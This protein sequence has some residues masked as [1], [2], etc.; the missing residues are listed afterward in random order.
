[1]PLTMERR[2]VTFR[3]IGRAIP[4]GSLKAFLPKGA[5]FP[6]LTADNPALRGWE[7]LVREQAQ[8]VARD[9]LFVG[10]IH[11]AIVFR[12]PRPT[13]LPKGVLHH[14]K[15]PDLDKLARGVLDALT[16]VLYADDKA[17][18]ELRVRKLYAPS[19][20]APS[21]CISVLEAAAPEPTQSSL[22]F[23][24]DAFPDPQEAL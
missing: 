23:A 5:K 18:V 17:V 13:S 16:D 7:Q 10:P 1:M 19:G 14:V 22:V 9:T 12:L 24:L 2:S 20:S 15:A 3:V 21:A 6:I 11:V 4:K 8:D